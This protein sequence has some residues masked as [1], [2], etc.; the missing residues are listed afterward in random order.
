MRTIKAPNNDDVWLVKS[1]LVL[2]AYRVRAND[3]KIVYPVE[4]RRMSTLYKNEI[5][6]D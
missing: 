5:Q 6:I 3:K 4:K 1:V 2:K